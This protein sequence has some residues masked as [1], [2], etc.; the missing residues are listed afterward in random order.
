M[1]LWECLPTGIAVHF[2]FSTRCNTFAK[3]L[4]PKLKEGGT[5][6]GGVDREGNGYGIQ[7]GRY[8]VKATRE[9]GTVAVNNKDGSPCPIRQ[10]E[11]EEDN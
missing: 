3:V 1:W 6:R 11:K 5:E 10:E 2:Y 8:W 9:W 7:K 4:H